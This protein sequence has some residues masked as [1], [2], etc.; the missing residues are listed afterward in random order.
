MHP[1]AADVLPRQGWVAM[2]AATAT[3]QRAINQSPRQLAQRARVNR[4]KAVAPSDASNRL[5]HQLRSGIEAL[6][7][8]DMSDVQV[9]RNSARPA[10]L[11]ALAF[12]Q[13]TNIHLAP[14]Q[15]RHLPHEAWHVAQQKAGRVKATDHAGDGTLINNSAQ[16]EA[17]ADQ[18][19]GRALQ[20][21]TDTAAVMASRSGADVAAIVQRIPDKFQLYM[22][23][24]NQRA[25]SVADKLAY[26]A[27]H[28]AEVGQNVCNAV[29][30]RAAAEAA[31]GHQLSNAV[32]ENVIRGVITPQFSVAGIYAQDTAH[33]TL[34]TQVLENDPFVQ[35]I[36]N[37]TLHAGVSGSRGRHPPAGG[38]IPGLPAGTDDR[39]LEAA[40]IFNRLAA[41]VPQ[42]PP[43]NVRPMGLP[44]AAMNPN[45]NLDLG[46]AAAR[47]NLVHEFG[48]HLE[49]NL[50]PADFATLHNFLTARTR[51][52]GAT[53]V[54]ADEMDGM[55]QAGY[56]FERH[57]GYD[58]DMPQINAGGLAGQRNPESLLSRVTSP[59]VG[60]KQVL[61][62][63]LNATPLRYASLVGS[64]MKQQAGRL[65]SAA[66]GRRE[67]RNWGG[68]GVEDFFV[69]NANN[70]Q[71]GYSAINHRFNTG[72]DVGSTEYLSTTTEF[73]NRPS[74][75]RE[76]VR[77]D[78][79]RAALFLYLANRPVYQ[80]IR[81]AFDAQQAD[82]NAH[83]DRLIHT[84]H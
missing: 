34:L 73:F 72:L 57:P 8:F 22:D 31:L 61:G 38:A 35:S 53:A 28:P 32:I 51:D 19:G 79:L 39:V 62:R 4:L 1:A 59:Y 18:M 7:G 75:A 63:G 65:A 13:G 83:L 58:I 9:H 64:G 76:L 11:N 48:H 71:I 15:E 21:R 42:L 14:G 56:F 3:T 50:G 80:Q 25:P 46:W 20:L 24:L 2:V 23:R 37:G 43:V 49:N 5:P 26:M 74:H 27:N 67:P 68:K 40:D 33:N 12:A 10:Q 36:M 66:T 70:A 47:G 45:G 52:A 77:T 55:H 29:A 16:L 78:P 30:A 41:P 17:E 82:P 44:H 60:L 54:D 6:S 84:I 81:N 69:H